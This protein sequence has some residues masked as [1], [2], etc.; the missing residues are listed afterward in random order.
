MAGRVVYLMD[1]PPAAD[2]ELWSDYPDVMSARQAADA[3][4]VSMP[5]IRRLIASQALRVVRIGRA[6]RITKTALLDY[7]GEGVTT[8][9]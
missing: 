3:L 7:I 9:E 8:H 1:T 2:F 4:Q 5:T 6:V